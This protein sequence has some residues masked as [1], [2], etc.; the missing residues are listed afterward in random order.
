[1]MNDYLLSIMM[2]QKEK[3]IMEEVNQFRQSHQ[4]HSYGNAILR[5]KLYSF[6]GLLLNHNNLKS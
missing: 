5:K 3:D 4:G 1:M 2:K 6:T